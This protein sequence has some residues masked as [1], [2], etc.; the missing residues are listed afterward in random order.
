MAKIL[1]EGYP[2]YFSGHLY[3]VYVDDLGKEWV[4]RGGQGSDG[5]LAVSGGVNQDR[6]LENSSDERID[7]FG[8]PITKEQRGS[9]EV[10]LPEGM[11]A[12][13]AWRI[14]QQ[15]ATVIDNANLDYDPSS[16]VSGYNSNALIGTLLALIGINV[17]DF[18]PNNSQFVPF[19]GM[20][21]VISLS[22]EIAGSDEAEIV[23]LNQ[24]DD[25]ISLG[26]GNDKAYGGG[27]SDTLIG[28]IGNDYYDGDNGDVIDEDA[29]DTLYVGSVPRSIVIGTQPQSPAVVQ[30][31]VTID[32]SNS[33]QEET[34]DG[35]LV[36]TDDG[37][38]TMDRFRNI[39]VVVLSQADDTFIF[40]D[41]L[42]Q[43]GIDKLTI[44]GG[45]QS[46][47]GDIADFSQASAGVEAMTGQIIVPLGDIDEDNF[48]GLA[49]L[50]Q[51]PILWLTGFEALIGSQGSDE[52]HMG[53]TLWLALGDGGSDRMSGYVFA[54]DPLELGYNAPFEQVI[55]GGDGDDFVLAGERAERMVGHD[56]DFELV[57]GQIELS[58][59][60]Q[61]G[62]NDILSYERSTEGVSV[63]LQ[64]QANVSAVL[65]GGFAAGDEAY[66]FRGVVGSAYDD[67][68]KGNNRSN[69]LVGGEGDDFIWGYGGNDTIEAGI[70]SNEVWTGDGK[71]L[72]RINSVEGAA[73][74]TLIHDFVLIDDHIDI[75][76]SRITDFHVQNSYSVENIPGRFINPGLAHLTL[77]DGG[78]ITLNI[79]GIA[80]GYEGYNI[81]DWSI[82]A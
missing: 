76:R 27:G 4:L 1:I 46:D 74:F 18:V 20:N 67:D 16:N 37:Y 71:D 2:I 75:D 39:E 21:H 36:V 48:E 72:V 6:L 49:S 64:N 41:K 73:E 81:H 53:D 9:K 17:D 24:E 8:F 78:V 19:I 13:A 34:D 22:A 51:A 25:V 82:F 29:T 42:F 5:N 52:I 31:G 59:T 66:G 56:A 35:I 7:D 43:T 47:I 40:S 15:Y 58:V 30:D 38:G 60:A 55:I 45:D 50:E 77:D 11:E 63:T 57:S 32:I 10:A 69:Y 54:D 28:G 68:L 26:G 3:L 61:N 62:D 79:V 65:S 23:Y 14:M 80:A 12:E 33:S 70:G 44:S